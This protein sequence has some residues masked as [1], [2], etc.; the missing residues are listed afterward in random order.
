MSITEDKEQRNQIIARR[1]RLLTA[2]TQILAEEQN[3]RR[4]QSRVNRLR[5]N[6][7]PNDTDRLLA[8]MNQVLSI[9][10]EDMDAFQYQR[11]HEAYR[12]FGGVRPALDLNQWQKLHDEWTDLHIRV[13]SAQDP[14]MPGQTRDLSLKERQRYAQLKDTLLKDSF[15][16]E[17]IM[18]PNPG[19]NNLPS[20]RVMMRQF[21]KRKTAAESDASAP[22]QISAPMLLSG[23]PICPTHQL[24]V[25]E[26][27]GKKQCVHS[28]L[29][30]CLLG[31]KIVDVVV[32][33][34]TGYFA[35][36]DGHHLPLLCGCCGKPLDTQ[37]ILADQQDMI[38]RTLLFLGTEN[39]V[40]AKEKR[41]DELTL[42]FSGTSPTDDGIVIPTAFT[43]ITQLKHPESCRHA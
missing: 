23:T 31:K 14:D 25:L 3:E 38:G 20:L 32:K 34:K 7:G 12:H 36:G 35:F 5:I 16:W 10:P 21:R 43:S 33:R 15:L 19:Q 1:E 39:S 29:E 30:N 22:D 27:G 8:Y 40:D 24:P 28:F 6:Y 42:H 41:F 11:Y 2:L 18:P 37:G 9:E 26:L 13:L 17:D 4:G